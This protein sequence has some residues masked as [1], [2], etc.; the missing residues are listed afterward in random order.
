MTTK[1]N[2]Q[3]NESPMAVLM[4]ADL[5]NAVAQVLGTLPYSQV[6]NVMTAL[7]QVVPIFSDDM[8]RFKF[9]KTTA[10]ENE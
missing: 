9:L 7:A 3:Q 2:K 4:N 10:D 5:F 8:E 1:Q 6:S